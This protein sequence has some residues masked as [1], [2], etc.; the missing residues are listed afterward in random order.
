M[1][2]KISNLHVKGDLST[3]IYPN[4]VAQNIPMNSIDFS[5]IQDDAII[6]QKIFNKAVTNAKIQNNAISTEKI[7]DSAISTDKIQNNAITN[8]KIVD[9]AITTDKIQDNAI[10]TDKIQNNAVTKD[11]IYDVYGS[12]NDVGLETNI[13]FTSTYD[14]ENGGFYFYKYGIIRKM[15]VE[16]L[17]NE[18][19]ASDSCIATIGSIYRPNR[20]IVVPCV[21]QTT[22]SYVIVRTS[23]EIII[24]SSIDDGFTLSFDIEWV[25]S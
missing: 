17:A 15:H 7:Q 3:I 10:T 2:N 6:T 19:I 16:I 12:K 22:L 21:I 14:V 18:N 1:A 5:K 4:I 23:G 11:K 20:Q 24:K 13:P 25:D 9:G 8:D